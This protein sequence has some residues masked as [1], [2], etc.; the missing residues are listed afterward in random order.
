MYNG[1]SSTH[2]YMYVYGVSFTVTY[3][4]SGEVYTYTITNVTADHTIVVSAG[5]STKKIYFKNNGSWVAATNVYKKV[6]G[7]WVL[8]SDLTTVFDSNTN[9]L[10]G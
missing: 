7:S 10:K 2:R 9:Y 5:A 1:A 6:N 8:Q 3:T 4:V